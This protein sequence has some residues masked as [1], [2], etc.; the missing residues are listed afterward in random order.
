M[1]I[2]TADCRRDVARRRR[3]RRQ[4]R[5]PRRSAARGTSASS[6]THQAS[7]SQA[8]AANEA[9]R[10]VFRNATAVTEST[11]NSLPALKPYQPNQ[12]RPVPSATSGM[13]C[14]PRSSARARADVEHRRQRR[15]AGDVVHHD[16]AGEVEHAP[17]LQDAA[18]PDHVH[19]GEVDEQQPE[20]E[21]EHVGLEGHAVG[22]GAGDQRRR[23]DAR[24]SSGRRRRRSA[25]S[26][27]FGRRRVERDAA[28]KRLVEV[29]DDRRPI[30]AARSRAR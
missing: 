23:D 14:G 20:R 2:S 11:R 9:A 19:E 27:V 1:P 24:T 18:A 3:D 30:V 22:E 12:S 8:I 25:G 10:S 28:Q 29:A 7:A 5:R 15:D 17:L 21:E 26:C 6:R 4:A 16:A 13:L